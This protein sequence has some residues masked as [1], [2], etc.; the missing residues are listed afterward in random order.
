MKKQFSIHSEIT[1]ERIG[2]DAVLKASI[3]EISDILLMVILKEPK[4]IKVIE[5]VQTTY[6][7]LEST[8]SLNL[9]GLGVSKISSEAM[10][11]VIKKAQIK[12]PSSL[13]S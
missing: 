9:I 7:M 1:E 10:E 2:V 8:N 11:D 6:E 5:L 13:K 12:N 3:Y 4:F